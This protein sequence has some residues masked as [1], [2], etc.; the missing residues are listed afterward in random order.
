M[1]RRKKWRRIAVLAALFC[2]FASV[3]MVANPEVRRPVAR[4]IHFYE[5]TDDMN[6]WERVVYS[7]V[8]A[9]VTAS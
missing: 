8:L 4:F 7:W 9:K 5:Q 6:L 2:L 1:C 3:K